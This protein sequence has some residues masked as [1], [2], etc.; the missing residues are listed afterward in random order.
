M[1]EVGYDRIL[2][3]YYYVFTIIYAKNYKILL[4]ASNQ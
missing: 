2:K 1:N 4:C 3:Q